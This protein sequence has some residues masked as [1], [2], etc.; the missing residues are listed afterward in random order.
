M[1]DIGIIH[2][3]DVYFFSLMVLI[4]IS[5]KVWN[6]ST[7]KTPQAR[8]FSILIVLNFLIIAA[9]CV[10]ILF[11]GHGG[12]ILRILLTAATTFGYCLQVLICLFWFWYTQ[13]VVLSGRTHLDIR[14]ILPAIPAAVCL[15]AA[16]LSPWTGWFFSLDALNVYHRG[17]LFGLV[18]GVSFLYLICG[19]WMIIRHRR[20]LDKRHLIALLCF[21]LPPTVGGLLQTFIIGVILLWPSMTISLLIIYMAIQNELMLLDYLTGINNRQSFDQELRRRIATAYGSWPFALMLLDIDNFR[22]INNRYGR[23]ECDEALK[24][25]ARLLSY[26]F[27]HDGFACRYGGDEFA[28]IIELRDLNDLHSVRGRL[29]SRLDE[30]NAASGKAWSLSVSVGC[31]PYVPDSGLTQDQFIMQVDKLLSLDKIIPGE[32]RVNGKR[33]G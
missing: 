8:V 24:T 15:I 19:Y 21:A 31:A 20:N 14:T 16:I 10:S 12:P 33:R 32:R 29:Q 1:I 18:A 3:L 5:V 2:T 28:V 26:F 13:T 9:D 22:T 25:F 23:V 7:V 30:W 4:L 6:N 17:P 27:R 11:D